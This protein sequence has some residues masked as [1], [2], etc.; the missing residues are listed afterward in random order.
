MRQP[1]LSGIGIVRDDDR[2]IEVMIE[3]IDK[4]IRLRGAGVVSLT[5]RSR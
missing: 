2:G 5:A 3:R 1:E 4:Q